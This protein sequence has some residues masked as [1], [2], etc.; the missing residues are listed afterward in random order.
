VGI[1]WQ[2]LFIAYPRKREALSDGA[3][4][5]TLS[6][7]MLLPFDGLVEGLPPLH[8]RLGGVHRLLGS[9]HRQIGIHRGDGHIEACQRSFRSDS[10]PNGTRG[11]YLSSP[12]FKIDRL[13]GEQER[14]PTR[15]GSRVTP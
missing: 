5:K 14:F 13:P 11:V 4:S 2:T 8:V 10:I 12:V 1:P 3:Q 7:D 15:C 9:Q 6:S